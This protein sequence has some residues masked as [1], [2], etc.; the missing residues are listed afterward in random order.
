MHIPHT[1][2]PVYQ[3]MHKDTIYYEY[4]F[5]KEKLKQN[6]RIAKTFRNT[7]RYIDDLLMLNN[8]IFEQEIS[9]IT[10]KIKKDHRN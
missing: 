7:F 4:K 6:S 3:C 10:T 2:T 5:M 8:P 9:N 1:N